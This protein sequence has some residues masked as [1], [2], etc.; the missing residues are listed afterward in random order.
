MTRTQHLHAAARKA[1][2]NPGRI[3]AVVEDP[4]RRIHELMR[5]W[6]KGTVLCLMACD[7]DGRLTLIRHFGA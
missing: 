3:V 4:D 2:R 7:R 6:G 5:Q 1:R